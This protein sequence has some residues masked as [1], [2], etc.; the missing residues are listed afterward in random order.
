MKRLIFPLLIILFTCS[1]CSEK[2]EEVTKGVRITFYDS[3]TKDPLNV[4]FNSVFA[5]GRTWFDFEE[6]NLLPLDPNADVTTYYFINNERRDSITFLY[7]KIVT[8]N[9]PDYCIDFQGITIDAKRTSL[10]FNCLNNNN[11]NHIT[12]VAIC[13]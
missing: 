9:S 13:Y 2:C 4:S 11:L 7:Q 10:D 3:D 12:D 1:T 8:R 6:N 5:K